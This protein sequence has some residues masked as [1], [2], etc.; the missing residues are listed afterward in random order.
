VLTHLCHLLPQ[1]KKVKLHYLFP[2][3]F[4]IVAV[5]YVLKYVLQSCERRD[6]YDV[7]TIHL[8]ILMKCNLK[9]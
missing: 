8:G 5:M 2:G 7:V 3:L 1:N 4:Y 9:D 6:I